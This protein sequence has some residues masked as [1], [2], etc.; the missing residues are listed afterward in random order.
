MY[1]TTNIYKVTRTY[2]FQ[3]WPEPLLPTK[4]MNRSSNL[5]KS[6]EPL[7]PTFIQNHLSLHFLSTTNAYK[8][9]EPLKPMIVDVSG[10]VQSTKA[11]KILRILMD[12]NLMF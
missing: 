5:Y 10:S 11:Y 1:R 7:R 8:Q 6:Q 12:F 9:P 4:S 2:N 3:N